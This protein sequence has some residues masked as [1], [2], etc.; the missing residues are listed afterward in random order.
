[1]QLAN[2]T[3][4][5]EMLKNISVLYVEDDPNVSKQL[6]R[7][8][9]KAVGSVYVAANGQEG[10]ESYKQYKPYVVITDIRMPILN[11]LEL[12]KSIREI[13]Q[14]VPI[15]VTT[16]F[17]EQEYFLKAIDT[18]IYRTEVQRLATAVVNQMMGEK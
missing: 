1:M 15:I 7:F 13:D 12:A 10:L 18:K 5:R 9:R 8:L 2:P 16:A 17:N 3:P 4:S 6:S 14:D 11:G